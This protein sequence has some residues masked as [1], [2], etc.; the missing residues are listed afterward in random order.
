MMALEAS[1]V[2]KTPKGRA[3]KGSLAGSWGRIDA[4]FRAG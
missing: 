3:L 2:Q 1:E 4:A